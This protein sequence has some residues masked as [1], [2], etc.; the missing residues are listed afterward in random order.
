VS[1]SAILDIR[2][3]V[4]HFCGVP[5]V[6]AA[7]LSVAQGSITALIGPNGAGKTSL[8]NVISGFQRAERG[9]VRFQGQ[10]IDGLPAYKIA[11]AGLVRTFQTTKILRRMTVLENMLLAGPSQPGES[12]WRVVFPGPNSRRER[13][14]QEKAWELLCSVKLDSLAHAY[15]GRLSGGQRKLLEFA[16]A[17][18]TEP[19]MLL[20][21]EPMAGVNPALRDQ[22]LEQMLAIREREG[23]TFLIIEHDL[24]T[25][26]S[27]SDTVAVMSEGRVIFVGAPDEAQQ[28]EDVINAY[29]GTRAQEPGVPRAES[30]P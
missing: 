6:N 13:E 19:R 4:K 28:N 24:E 25:I 17:L 21:D 12:L 20:L 10:R 30:L 26:M 9:E 11:R 23:M 2:G 3:M 8:F 14:L 15:A 27:V 29:L 1:N 22:L 18:M 16:R 7:S 5:A